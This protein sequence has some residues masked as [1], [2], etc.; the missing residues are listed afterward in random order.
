MC[1]RASYTICEHSQTN[2]QNAHT[3]TPKEL[4][5]GVDGD[6]FTV[7]S[8]NHMLASFKQKYLRDMGRNGTN[9]LL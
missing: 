5:K 6:L 9:R 1:N 3:K 4:G 7:S 8:R 2:D